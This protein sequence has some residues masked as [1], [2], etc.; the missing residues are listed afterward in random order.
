MLLLRPRTRFSDQIFSLEDTSNH[1]QSIRK[2]ISMVISCIQC[3][4]IMLIHLAEIQ[5]RIQN[6]KLRHGYV[7]LGFCFIKGYFR[8]NFWETSK[9]F[10]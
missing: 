3:D 5:V 1:K 7:M 10:M 8:V 9:W 6:P 2:G 4:C